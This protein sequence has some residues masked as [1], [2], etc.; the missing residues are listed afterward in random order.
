MLRRETA[1][2]ATK[3]GLIPKN[4]E[5][6]QALSE[7]YDFYLRADTEIAEAGYCAHE[8]RTRHWRSR[9]QWVMFVHG[10][11]LMQVTE[12]GMGELVRDL[13]PGVWW[14]EHT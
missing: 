9:K 8:E 5:L 2:V 13:A 3:Q 11:D 1:R 10:F 7:I 4:S 12:L 6:M 14:D